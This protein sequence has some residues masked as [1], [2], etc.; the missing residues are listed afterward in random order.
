MDLRKKA[1]GLGA[2]VR[3]RRRGNE[4]TKTWVKSALSVNLQNLKSEKDSLL[5]LLD[6][7]IDFFPFSGSGDGLF[8][9]LDV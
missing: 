8:E 1:S 3:S 7:S 9:T 4:A 5:P 2:L 6:A